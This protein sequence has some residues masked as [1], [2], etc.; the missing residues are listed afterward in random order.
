MYTNLIHDNEYH[1]IP[2]STEHCPYIE[3]RLADA[4][5]TVEGIMNES[6]W[7]IASCLELKAVEQAARFISHLPDNKAEDFVKKLQHHARWKHT[8]LHKGNPRRKQPI[9]DG[10]WQKLY[11]QHGNTIYRIILLMNWEAYHEQSVG[12]DAADTLQYRARMAWAKIMDIPANQSGAYI[13]FPDRWLLTVDNSAE[14]LCTLF[15]KVSVLC[16]LPS[17]QHGQSLHAFGSTRRATRR[18]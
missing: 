5:A 11:T 8:E 12:Y 10:I 4:L 16:T 15:P 2:L 17:E 3:Q 9:I 13:R 1:G 7:V 14:G 6:H 18:L